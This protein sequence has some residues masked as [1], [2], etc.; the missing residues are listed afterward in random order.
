MIDHP[1]AG[2]AAHHNVILPLE[3]WLSKEFLADQASSSVGESHSSYCF[4]ER[5]W[6]LAIDAATPVA[7]S[8]TDL[9]SKMNRSLPE[10]WDDLLD[11][12]SAGCV[13][14][15]CIPQDSLMNFYMVCST[16]GEDP[17]QT[18]TQ[19]V[20]EDIGIS[21][22]RK[23]RELVS[24]I[25]QRC[26]DWNPIQ[27]YEEMTRSDL[28][29]YCPF[30]YGYSNY[31]REGYARTRLEFHDMV[32]IADNNRCRTTLGGTG[33]AISASCLH[34]ELAASYLQFVAAPTCQK[35]LYFD[36]GGQPG[37]R[38]AWLSDH[39]NSQTGNFF[40]NTLPALDRAFLRPRYHGHMLFQDNAGAPIRDY[41]ISGG[42][43]RDFLVTLNSLYHVR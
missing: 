29:A 25:D 37:H 32:K 38:Q 12:A 20:S 15:P 2:S 24:R 41:L 43:E 23:L 34:K 9:L 33:L 22:L 18:A 14:I 16:M 5:Q 21:A 42:D 6:A 1:W 11:L 28:F 30:A 3:D 40:L 39:T 27:V 35:S 26:F 19:V 4:N 13:A 17:C 8:R 7:A 36:A 31:A 10:T